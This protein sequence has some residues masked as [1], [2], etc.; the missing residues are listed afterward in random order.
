MQQ[1]FYFAAEFN[2]A[3]VTDLQL[4]VLFLGLRFKIFATT[5]HET[6]TTKKPRKVFRGLV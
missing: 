2:K 6:Q 5:K 4:L 3:T 1:H